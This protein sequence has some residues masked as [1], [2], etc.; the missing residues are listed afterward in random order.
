MRI[1][2]DGR[3]SRRRRP[4]HIRGDHVTDVDGGF[5]RDTD[6]F[7]GQ[8]K[9]LGIRFGR[10]HHR[11]IDDVGDHAARAGGGGANTGVPE[12]LASVAVGV[13]HHD[14]RETGFVEGTQSL[15]RAGGGLAPEVGARAAAVGEHGEGIHGVPP[16]LARDCER[17]AQGGQVAVP[18]GVGP[19]RAIERANGFVVRSRHSGSVD[20]DSGGGEGSRHEGAV[21]EHEHAAGVE[22]H[23]LTGNPLSGRGVSD[24]FSVTAASPTDPASYR[25]LVVPHTHW[26]REWYRPFE[27]FRLALARVVDGVLDVLERD[28]DFT[29]FTLDGQAIVL[30]DYL[31]LRPENEARLRALLRSGRIEVGPSYILPDEFLVSGEALVRNLLLGR[32]VCR[33]F[34]VEPSP[35]GYLP[36]SFGHP[37]QL[38]QLLAGFGIT[39]FIFSRGLGDEVE[40]VGV[41]F[42]WCALDGSEVLAF[43]QLPNY[44]NFAAVAGPEDGEAR[45]RA[46]VGRAGAALARAGV[47]LILLCNG[48]DHLPVMPQLPR[49]C[50]EL[51]ERIPGASF[52]IGRYANYVEAVG[53]VEVPVWSGELLGSRLQNVLR[54]VDSARLYVKRANEQAEQRLVAV[55]ALAA[56]RTLQDGTRFPADEFRLAW[57]DLLRCHPH[58]T[59]CGCSCDEVHRDALARYESLE[60]TV[61]VLESRAVEGVL[62]DA[63]ATRVSVINPLPF[64]RCAVIELA[65]RDPVLVEV[66]GFGA[67]SVETVAAQPAPAAGGG[68]PA[69]ENDRF[70]VEA[71]ADG[72]I[73]VV[74]KQDDR[75]YEGLH[76]L[77]DEFDMGDLY[78]FCPVEQ[79]PAW[80][81]DRAEIGILADGPVMSELE[82]RVQAD[83]PAGLDP[84]FRPL[85]ETVPL[86]VRTVVRLVRGSSRVEFRT[87]IDNAGSDHRLRVIF[88]VPGASGPVRAE[89]QFALLERPL[90]PA[91]PR[92]DWVEPPDPTAHTCGAV[93]VGPIGL[94]TRG[95]PEYEARI[96]GDG[97]ELCLTLLRCVGVIAKPAGVLATRPQFAG[98]AVPTPDGQ[99]LGR[100]ECEYAFVPGADALD[101]VALRREAQDYRRGFVTV[102]GEVRLGSPLT[103]TGDVIFSCLKGAEDGDGLILRCFNPS[104]IATTARVE[105]TA[106]IFRTR[107]DETGAEPVGDGTVEVGA[108]EIVTLRLRPRFATAG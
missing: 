75:R 89:G 81:S 37:A 36:D 88:P 17:M 95:L 55:E 47:H 41:V 61:S 78:N 15:E 97:P 34:G 70:R 76:A 19:G 101:A 64:R 69:I 7:Q 35:V 12:V 83:R 1:E 43:Q 14:D 30:E 86:T 28:P 9:D 79:A 58:D 27:Y 5:S 60:R 21:G 4:S 20:F 84:E 23:R 45:V 39:S 16:K 77:E 65:G 72:T 104:A 3:D 22:Q 56:L 94:I 96:A 48:S 63:E 99:C 85:G 62:D 82:L 102:A 8:A 74:D 73:T 31:E 2:V 71:R 68:V 10:A 49:L 105:V 11:R 50:A 57:R 33:R 98:P 51:E 25:Y 93:A 29:S 32:A 54:G 92:A 44:G 53:S 91:E 26:D 52:E 24:A 18:Q 13:G 103:L 40:E 42:R 80:R 38:P 107:L 67:A 66:D 46:I 87:T 59:I 106:D 100:Q 108:G 90:T 6:A